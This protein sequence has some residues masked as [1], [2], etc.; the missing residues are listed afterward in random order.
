MP[1]PINNGGDVTPNNNNG[2]APNTT[3]ANNQVSNPN[4][5]VDYN[6]IQE[7]INTKNV[8]TEESILK[9]Y[10]Q[11]QGLSA[12]EMDIAINT[13]KQNKVNAEK[14]HAQALQNLQAENAQLK[15]RAQE[16]ALNNEG[17][18]CGLELGL[19]AKV[20]P[21]IIKLADMSKAINEKGEIVKDEIITAFNKVLEDLPQLKS[22]NSN[23]ANGG[24]VK[25][26]ADN[27]GSNNNTDDQ[28]K[29]I[30]KF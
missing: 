28:L 14:E 20:I 17:I 22:S 6:K 24:F 2:T 1:E 30:F 10:L 3:G 29:E 15:Q 18:Q 27:T 13:Y 8:R 4:V 7:I 25:I 23:P 9:G 21:S 19:D 16:T 12:D 26:G 11:K 5:E